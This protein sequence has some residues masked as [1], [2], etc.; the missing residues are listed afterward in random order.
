MIIIKIKKKQKK[1]YYDF[2]LPY[3]FTETLIYEYFLFFIYLIQKLI[4]L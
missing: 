1:T 4:Y 2:I 3:F